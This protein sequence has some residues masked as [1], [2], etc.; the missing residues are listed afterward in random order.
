MN[1]VNLSR[2]LTPRKTLFIGLGGS[3]TKTVQYIKHFMSQTLDLESSDYY[4]FLFIDTQSIEPISGFDPNLIQADECVTLGTPIT[5]ELIN[6]RFIRK[7]LDED[8][9]DYHKDRGII[10]TN[11]GAGNIR[12]Y[13]LIS[14]Y[15]HIEKVRGS[16]ED[17]I[18]KLQEPKSVQL[19]PDMSNKHILEP[20][21]ELDI[22][23]C[24][25]SSI[26]GGTGAGIFLDIAALAK[27]LT[28]ES[29]ASNFGFFYTPNTFLDGIDEPDVSRMEMETI[30]NIQA[31][32]YAS[33][34]EIDHFC[35]KNSWFS[36]YSE[37]N[38]V[39]LEGSHH[40]RLIDTV[41]LIDRKTD[42]GSEGTINLTET[43]KKTAESAIHLTLS[44]IADHLPKILI[45]S[46]KRDDKYPRNINN[47]MADNGQRTKV[48]SSF[49]V[50]TLNIPIKNLMDL[51]SNRV[52]Y[53]F[54]NSRMDRHFNHEK[55]LR[56]VRRD[57]ATD[58]EDL[59]SKVGIYYGK[60][61]S[62]PSR[63]NKIDKELFRKLSSF[64]IENIGLD[65]S[66]VKKYRSLDRIRNLAQYQI[67]S[68]R[69]EEIKQ[70]IQNISAKY[71][72]DFKHDFYEDINSNKKTKRYWHN[73]SNLSLNQF[74]KVAINDLDIN[75][76]DFKII[77]DIIL[78]EVSEIIQQL[79]NYSP[80]VHQINIS[81]D[82][83]S[84]AKHIEMESNWFRLLGLDLDLN[85]LDDY[86]EVWDLKEGKYDSKILD[87]LDGLKRTI[88]F[89]IEST[90]V[91]DL[92][93]LMEWVKA[94]YNEFIADP[95][96]SFNVNKANH[97]GYYRG[98]KANY[99]QI[100]LALDKGQSRNEIVADSADLL[101]E[102][103]EKLI[104]RKIRNK[105]ISDHLESMGAK[106]ID[107]SN[108][109]NYYDEL[110]DYCDILFMENIEDFK[111]YNP[112]LF[113]SNHVCEASVAQIAQASEPML[114]YQSAELKSNPH[115]YLIK[116]PKPE[117]H[118]Y[119]PWPETK[120]NYNILDGTNER[121]LTIFQVTDG[122]PV[123]AIQKIEEWY[124]V[125]SRRSRARWKEEGDPLPPL[126][127]FKEAH[128]F[129][130]AYINRQIYA[131]MRGIKE[132]KVIKLA[133]HDISASLFAQACALNIIR[134]NPEGSLFSYY[135]IKISEDIGKA[136]FIQSMAND[137]SSL[138]DVW[139]SILDLKEDREESKSQI[140]K[141][142]ADLI[143]RVNEKYILKK[144]INHEIETTLDPRLHDIMQKIDD[145][146]D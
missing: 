29:K 33:L 26:V 115:R 13:S 36:K 121:K 75:Y 95:T 81:D 31:N 133:L 18:L 130:E 94:Q 43:Y 37:N 14:L 118:P 104:S 111:L 22:M 109:M 27:D 72:S 58:I 7:R 126:H 65:L 105:S 38:T 92:L 30:R 51:F 89:E 145:L 103:I 3:G 98:L 87:L 19:I 5:D 84:L 46:G 143:L 116:P 139:E 124:D 99:Q 40:E 140:R 42:S 137:L 41:F 125:Y 114:R 35:R 80:S 82:V 85:K 138:W 128:T 131:L 57:T 96:S 55:L 47:I 70:N 6:N 127:I 90:I 86:K 102:A 50:H 93:E 101:P 112:E 21:P 79:E 61:A 69:Y 1:T 64:I 113:E 34:K 142:M 122:I 2:K 12:A 74:L 45:N 23:V 15:T 106:I 146:E 141:E 17:K 134:S 10:D 67:G 54:F 78:D 97:D 24:I 144:K 68:P 9:Y 48:Y 132:R 136:E 76:E 11:P 83:E 77:V 8:F 4:Q 66:N 49:G 73:H 32:G 52:Q 60:Q 56:L 16:I 110:R 120:K 88:Q 135:G 53:A 63:V 123:N 108:S 62:K 59:I 107:D 20:H 44:Q 91:I 129:R 28:R 119:A 117:R 100:R 25:F 39:E 71:L